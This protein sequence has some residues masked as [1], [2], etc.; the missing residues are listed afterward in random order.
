MWPLVIAWIALLVVSAILVLQT[1]HLSLS[2]LPAHFAALPALQQIF[3]LLA[4]VLAAFLMASAIRQSSRLARYARR[5]DFLT[6]RLNGVRD[7]VT[8]TDGSQQNLSS[9]AEHLLASDPEN[10]IVALQATNCGSA[11]SR[12][13]ARSPNSRPMPTTSTSPSGCTPSRA[14]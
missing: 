10:A 12:S 11:R 3:L 8:A 7:A 5:V 9:A 1:L 4:V 6:K 2:E 13:T 14:A